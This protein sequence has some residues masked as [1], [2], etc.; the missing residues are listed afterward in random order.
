MYGRRRNIWHLPDTLYR[1]IKKA[2]FPRLNSATVGNCVKTILDRWMERKRARRPRGAGSLLGNRKSRDSWNGKKRA[3]TGGRTSGQF[4]SSV[5]LKSDE[6]RLELVSFGWKRL[7]PDT[8]VD[9]AIMDARRLRIPSA[10]I[11]AQRSKTKNVA[12]WFRALVI[13]KRVPAT[14]DTE[15]ELTTAFL[16]NQQHIPLTSRT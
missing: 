8:V 14:V 1:Y 6:S 9:G 5:E 12:D 2:K 10:D 16:R 3:A 7:G 11:D 4:D 15:D 13:V